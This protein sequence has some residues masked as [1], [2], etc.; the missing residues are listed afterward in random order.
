MNETKHVMDDIVSSLRRYAGI[1]S[2]SVSSNSSMRVFIG[3]TIQDMANPLVTAMASQMKPSHMIQ[4]Q[5]IDSF[6]GISR[7]CCE[8]RE[9][10]EPKHSFKTKGK[11]Y[12]ER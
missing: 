3:F 12:Q 1:E 5:Y 7:E 11:M 6:D 9:L 2:I 8:F 10:R 4:R